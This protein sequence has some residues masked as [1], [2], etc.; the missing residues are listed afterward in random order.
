VV[1]SHR[2]VTFERITTASIGSPFSFAL[3]AQHRDL[4]A[5]LFGS[6]RRHRIDASS[7]EML[8]DYAIPG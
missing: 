7:T 5:E 1:P 3:G 4:D 2:T 6:E 8:D